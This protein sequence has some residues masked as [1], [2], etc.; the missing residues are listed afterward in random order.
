MSYPNILLSGL[1]V[2]LWAGNWPASQLAL[3]DMPPVTFRLVTLWGGALVLVILCF[4]AKDKMAVPMK[5]WPLLVLLAVLNVGLFNILSAFSIAVL[6][7]GRAALIAFTM[8]V[9]VV[10]IQLLLGVRYPLHQLMALVA[11]VAGIALI[12]YSVIRDPGFSA[13]AAGLMAIAALSWASGSVLM[14]RNRLAV[15]GKA[16]TMW[17]LLISGVLTVFILPVQSQPLLSFPDKAEGWLGLAYATLIGMA[18]CQGLWFYLL[19][20]IE[21]ARAAL[22]LLAIP[23][24]GTFL[25]WSVA[26]AAL[27]ILDAAAL[28]LLLISALLTVRSVKRAQTS[29][30]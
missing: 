20:R 16:L 9:W 26:G 10:V 1:L 3:T 5:E 29:A 17:M 4:R 12:L 2:V 27:S 22:L 25:S 6:E 19:A 11:G 18:V 13:Q 15:S 8:P 21:T 30:P 7:G 28:L 24:V 14:A 23:P